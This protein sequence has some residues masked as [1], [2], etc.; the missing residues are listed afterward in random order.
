MAKVCRGD[1]GNEN[2]QSWPFLALTGRTGSRYRHN[3]S[4]ASA[5]GSPSPRSVSTAL[6]PR[7]KRP[8]DASSAETGLDSSTRR[9]SPHPASLRVCPRWNW[10][11]PGT[12]LQVRRENRFSSHVTSATF[13]RR[14]HGMGL[15][16]ISKRCIRSRK[17]RS[18]FPRKAPSSARRQ[19]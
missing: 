10:R 19:R 3:R 14:T 6:Q 17:T 13:P 15:V 9:I 5:S 11:Q 1:R 18:S 16:F 4:R 12:L 7:S 8:V 2:R